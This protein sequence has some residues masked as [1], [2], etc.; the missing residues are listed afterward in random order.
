MFVVGNMFYDQDD[1]WGNGSLG[2]ILGIVNSRQLEV[3]YAP[4]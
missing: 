3:Q 2:M 1:C 4:T